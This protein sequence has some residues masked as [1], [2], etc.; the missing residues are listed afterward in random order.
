M[1]CTVWNVVLW[2]SKKQIKIKSTK[3]GKLGCN[4]AFDYLSNLT[5]FN[6]VKCIGTAG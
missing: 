6:L 3:I 2:Q 5:I 1:F 4:L